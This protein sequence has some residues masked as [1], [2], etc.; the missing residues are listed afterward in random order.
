MSM[1]EKRNINVCTV[2]IVAVAAKNSRYF[3]SPVGIQ[4]AKCAYA[5]LT[6]LFAGQ[7]KAGC[8]FF[9]AP[10]QYQADVPRQFGLDKLQPI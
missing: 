4:Q 8:F 2:Y 7:A 1:Q 3:I 9:V 10:S 6:K 5:E